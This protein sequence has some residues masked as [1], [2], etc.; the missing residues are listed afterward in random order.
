[1]LFT[2]T[3]FVITQTNSQKYNIFLTKY[4][5]YIKMLKEDKKNVKV[6]QNQK[7]KNYHNFDSYFL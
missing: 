3:R 4:I 1:M 6:K 7:H 5:H 2:K